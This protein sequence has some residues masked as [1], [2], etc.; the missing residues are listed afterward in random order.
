M[1][2]S[3]PY[4]SDNEILPSLNKGELLQV[5]QDKGSIAVGA[6][7]ELV[8]LNPVEGLTNGNALRQIT[9]GGQEFDTDLPENTDIFN[10]D[11]EGSQ[12]IPSKLDGLPVGGFVVSR[13]ETYFDDLG[14]DVVHRVERRIDVMQSEKGKAVNV[15]AFA[16]SN[17]D[18]WI[19]NP[20][21]ENLMT[22]LG[23]L[24]DGKNIK[25]FP[26]PDTVVATAH[27]L[28][29]EIQLIPEA[30]Q[31]SSRDYLRVFADGKYPVSTANET[32][33]KHDIQDDHLPAVIL[34]GMPLKVAL[35]GVAKEAIASGDQEKMN[36]VT[37]AVDGFT[38]RLRGVV[39]D[40]V[41]AAYGR[42]MGRGTLIKAGR[43]LGLSDEVT[44][45]ILEHAQ[46][47][48]KGFGIEITEL[49]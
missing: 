12:I 30:G 6:S 38:A 23:F 15:N 35:Q 43:A 42:E 39:Y 10:E 48:A 14:N 34:G 44:Q 21:T 22:Q 27:N 25:A 28:G 45:G 16:N 5:A 33:Y 1:H 41:G 31:L 2:E 29:V 26:T 46:E 7:P 8:S 9:L 13:N 49:D 3:F 32:Y 18:T 19:L 36:D 47:S 24:V 11:T 20:T 4:Q 40:G 17:H 37:G